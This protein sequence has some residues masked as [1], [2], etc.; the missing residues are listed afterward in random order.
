MISTLRGSVLEKRPPQ[1]VI[2]VGG[3]GYELEM[4]ISSICQLPE[5]GG[6]VLVYVH[7]IIREDADALYGFSSWAER[8][9]FR[10]LLKVNSIGPKTALVLLSNLTASELVNLVISG[11]VNALCRLPT[12]GKKSAERLIVEL[13]DRLVK[14]QL[15]PDN[16]QLVSQGSVSPSPAVPSAPV[17]SS[18]RHTAVEALIQLGY[19]PKQAEALVAAVYDESK[20]VENIIKDA[21]KQTFSNRK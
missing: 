12:I 1:V 13:K 16:S 5:K 15:D 9:L 8:S 4:P 14:W 21:L 7:E 20:S 19:N 17:K 2:E 18:S 11:D 3:I 10:E 6:T